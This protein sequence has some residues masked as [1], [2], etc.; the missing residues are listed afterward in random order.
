LDELRRLISDLR[1]PHLDDL[2]LAAAIRWYAKE[3]QT[4]TG[5]EVQV[6]ISGDQADVPAA[7]RLAVFRIAQEALTNVV[8][9][10]QARLAKVQ[11]CYRDSEVVLL[12]RDEGCGFEAD[13]QKLAPR[14]AWG[15]LGMQERATLLGGRLSVQSKPGQGTQVEA[16]LPY[17]TSE[18]AR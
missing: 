6:E 14:P 10:S 7:V 1:P 4:R 15:L 16:I 13:A 8:K 18:T 11:L 9:H 3:V 17:G 5:L 2:G 12:V